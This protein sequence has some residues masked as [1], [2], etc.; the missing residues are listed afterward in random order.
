VDALERVHFLLSKLDEHM[1][2]FDPR[3]RQKQ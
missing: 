3:E 1:S 2:Q